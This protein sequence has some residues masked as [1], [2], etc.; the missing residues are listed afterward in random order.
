M[1]K[2]YVNPLYFPSF[3][4]IRAS[5]TNRSNECFDFRPT[6]AGWA[7]CALSLDE[8]L[9]EGWRWPF[10]RR[11]SARGLLATSPAASIGRV[12]VRRVRINI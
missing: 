8:V 5:N 11:G 6:E 7:A 2:Q 3:L 12:E 9:R 10:P 1:G 4:S